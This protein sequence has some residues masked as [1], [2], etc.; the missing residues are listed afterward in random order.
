MVMTKQYDSKA[1]EETLILVNVL[2]GLADSI[3]VLFSLHFV[4]D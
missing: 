3:E 4:P 2:K 1:T